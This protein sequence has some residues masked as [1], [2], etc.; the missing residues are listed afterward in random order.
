MRTLELTKHYGAAVA[1]SGLT[2]VVPRGE[3]FG[4]L[5]P[6]GSG[7]TTA[8]KLL[9][10]LSRPTGGEAWVLG[11]PAGRPPDPQ[12]GRVPARAVPLPGMAQRGRGARAA[13][14]ARRSRPRRL[15]GADLRGA[16]HGRA[17]RARPRQGR[18]LLQRDAA[19][20]RSR[21]C[22]ARP[23]RAG[24][25][26][27]ANLRPRPRRTGRHADDH[28]PPSGSWMRGLSQLASPG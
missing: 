1:L 14:P 20:S 4:F 27:R 26:R 7:K 5:G 21:C 16:D 13:L 3:V 8:V 28:P 23:P 22:A 25:P 18:D 19:A 9:L 15:A 2:M 10:G 11:R 17:R 6:N 24:D 12:Q